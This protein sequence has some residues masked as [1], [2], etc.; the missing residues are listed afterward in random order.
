MSVKSML[1]EV[2]LTPGQ[3][4]RIA[5]ANARRA[6]MLTDDMAATALETGDDLKEAIAEGRADASDAP[7]GTTDVATGEDVRYNGSLMHD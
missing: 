6:P 3:V 5:R 1:R 2:G 7:L 4:R